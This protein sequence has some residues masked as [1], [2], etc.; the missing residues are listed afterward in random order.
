MPY[1]KSVAIHGHVDKTLKYILDPDKTEELMYTS[2]INC[3]TEGDLAYAQM[4]TVY[5]Q[6]SR[7]SYDAPQSKSGKSAVKA[8]HYIIS[9]ADSENVTP[10]LAHKIAKAL[11]RKNFGE[12][13][14]AVIATHT[15]TDHVH[16]HVLVN[17]YSISG[18]RFYDNK[19]SLRI[20]RE[21]TNGVCRAFGVT[22]ALNFENKGRSISHYEWKCRKNGVSWKEHI[23]NAIDSLIPNV[24]S[25]DELLSELERLGYSIKRDKHIYI[26]APGQKRSI[27]LWKLGEDYTEESLNARIL[28]RMVGGG[29]GIEH[30][31][32]TAIERAY[33]SVIGEIRIL[34]SENRKVQRRTDPNAPY[35]VNN[36]LDIYRL[37]AQLTVINRDKIMSIEDLKYR[38][39]RQG[40]EYIA[41]QEQ[42][43][44][45]LLEQ[46]Q[47]QEL[48]RQSEFYFTNANRYDLSAEDKNRLEIYISSMQAN[49]IHSPDDINCW[50]E[51]NTKLHSDIMAL[52]NT[53][54]EKKN[55]LAM[56]TDIRD[57]YYEISCGDYISKLVEEEKLRREQERQKKSQ[58]VKKKKG[59]R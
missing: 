36:D 21:N 12:D 57:T 48:I 24:N 54:A 6:Y 42:L 41:L 56:Y 13:A 47:V 11:V 22:P 4:K 15:N 30:F 40:A 32:N 50:R 9:F 49:D 37:S 59:S 7:R 1:C 23:R 55:K 10:E 33:I 52:K 18:Q 45:L 35:D 39:D 14:Q 34:A 20:V 27:S 25:F 44:R 43:S 26:K 29:N 2:S 8:I 5:E 46:E 28:W 17:S 3:M 31:R 16:C 53:I 58:E 51:Q 38:I 19:K